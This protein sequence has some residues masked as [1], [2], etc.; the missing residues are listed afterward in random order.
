MRQVDSLAKKVGVS[1]N[2]LIEMALGEFVTQPAREI[3]ERLLA[4]VEA[5]D[6]QP[7]LFS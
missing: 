3:A 2:R 7:D 5:R 6:A 4:E 1:R